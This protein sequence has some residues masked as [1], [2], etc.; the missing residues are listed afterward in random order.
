MKKDNLP[1]SHN[2]RKS[3]R[4]R[5]KEK[6]KLADE[7]IDSVEKS[8]ITEDNK[9][10]KW[11]ALVITQFLRI[12]EIKNKE[13]EEPFWKKR[14]ESKINTLR[15]NVSFIERWAAEMLWKVRRLDHLYRVKR[16]GYKRAAEELKQRIKAKATTTKRYKKRVKQYLQN[17]L[18]QSNLSK[19]YQELDGKLYG[20]NIIPNKEK[21]REFQSGIWE[22]NVKRNENAEKRCKAIT[23]RILK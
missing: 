5:F 21:T 23:N 6:T 8:K 16:K 14:I 13:K 20:E 18:F 9:L 3:D 2:L 7:F 22:K 10:V 15:K 19:F 11:G 4:L 1:N 17:R 12:K